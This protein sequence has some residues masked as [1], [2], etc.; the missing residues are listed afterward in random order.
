MPGCHSICPFCMLDMEEC[1]CLNTKGVIMA[2]KV[3]VKLEKAARK[4]GGDRYVG[5]LKGQDWSVY[6][7]QSITRPDNSPVPVPTLTITIE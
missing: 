6:L 4:S 3:E 5:Q 1:K 2:E 7:P